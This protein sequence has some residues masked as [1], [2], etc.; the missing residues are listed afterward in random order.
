MTVRMEPC[1]WPVSYSACTECEPLF[2]MPP[3]G[4]A[5]FERTAAT[6]LWNWT[7]Q[8]LGLCEVTV[9]PCRES[10]TEGMSTYYGSGPYPANGLGTGP[11]RPVILNGQWYNLGCARCGDTCGCTQTPAVVLPGPVDEVS[12]VRINGAVLAEDAYRVDNY[13]ILV[14]TDGGEWPAC[15]NLAAGPDEDGTWQVT[16]TQGIPVPQGGRIAAGIL[17][18][19]LAKAACGDKSCGL[20]QR[21]QTI[22]RQ[23]VTVAMLDA[24]DDIDTGHTGIWLIDSWVASVMKPRRRSQVYSPDI[25][26]PSPRRTTFGG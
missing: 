26:R 20:P 10:C 15:Q 16:Y 9:R 12:E 5:E 1:D 25:P 4:T 14:R 24:F 2:S 6:F 17:A 8:R 18:C 13:R 19:E 7:G 23:G 3:S 11:W 21:V 22:S